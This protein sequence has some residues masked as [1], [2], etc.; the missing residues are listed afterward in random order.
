MR[1][2]FAPR[3]L[4]D[5]DAILDYIHRRSPQGARNVSVA[6]ERTVE[7]LAQS[8]RIGTL[9][10][11][12]DVYRFPLSRYRYTIFYRIDHARDVV[13][14]VCIVHGSRIRERGEIPGEGP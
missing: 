13:E 10:D 2:I 1:L 4:R 5:I 3:A 7:L 14:I 6:I 12:P 8:P 9:T 11:L